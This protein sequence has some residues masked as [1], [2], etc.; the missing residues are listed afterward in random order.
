VNNSMCAEIV[1]S[2][3]VLYMMLGRFTKLDIKFFC[4]V[5]AKNSFSKILL[6]ESG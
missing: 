3:K 2:G 5:T 1:H 4:H 6:V